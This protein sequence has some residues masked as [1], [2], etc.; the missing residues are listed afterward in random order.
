LEK[1]IWISAFMAVGVKYN[2]NMGT[3]EK[4]HTKEIRSVIRELATIAEKV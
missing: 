1:L 2:C 3:V 4:E